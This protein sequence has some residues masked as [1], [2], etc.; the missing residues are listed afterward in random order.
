MTKLD[1]ARYVIITG[2]DELL[3]VDLKVGDAE[4]QLTRALNDGVD[5]YLQNSSEIDPRKLADF[6]LANNLPSEPSTEI[7][8]THLRRRTAGSSFN[9]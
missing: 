8:R 9:P 1:S 5:A 3:A 2:K 4:F 7:Q 6:R